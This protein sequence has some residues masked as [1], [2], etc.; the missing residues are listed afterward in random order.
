M[1]RQKQ[2]KL[3][4]WMKSVDSMYRWA[5]KNSDGFLDSLDDLPDDLP[6]ETRADFVQSHKMQK[7]DEFFEYLEVAEKALAEGSIRI[8]RGIRIPKSCLGSIGE[9]L[10]CVDVGDAGF[11]WSYDIRSAY[12]YGGGSRSINDAVN[13]ILHGSIDFEG[14]DWDGG[15]GSY[16]IFP[17][18]R[19]IR[20]KENTEIL[21]D[22]INEYT[23]DPPVIVS[24]GSG[25]QFSKKRP[26]ESRE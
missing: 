12:P 24:S 11:F 22:G 7:E 9:I 4:A 19:E 8:Y 6:R 5:K 18:E 15:F 23:I 25:E 16:S 20:V 2:R 1:P 3:P 17:E 13:V 21:L 10:T 14:I 26:W